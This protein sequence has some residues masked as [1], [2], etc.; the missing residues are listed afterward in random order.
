MYHTT[1]AT[2]FFD[3]AIVARGH[4]MIILHPLGT[5]PCASYALFTA[6][7]NP[8]RDPVDW[9]VEEQERNGSWRTLSTVKSI[10]APSA[11]KKSYPRLSVDDLAPFI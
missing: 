3:S 11:R 4:S 6:N 1:T 5:V 2:Q 8:K 7:D 9:T 10:S